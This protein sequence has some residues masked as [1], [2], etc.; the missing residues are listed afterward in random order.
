MECWDKR[1]LKLANEVSTWS[2][3]PSTKVGVV[4]SDIKTKQV[5]ALGYNGFPRGVND[6]QERLLNRELKLQMTIHAEANA[7][8]FATAPLQGHCIYVTRPPCTQCAAKIIQSGLLR[9][10]YISPDKIFEERWKTDI[11]TSLLMF[12]EVGV[13][14]LE[15]TID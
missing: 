13:D 9:V 4:I 10:V 11:E 15:Y 12:K 3:D 5:I 6:T 14:V 8:L 2:K 1:F 7:I